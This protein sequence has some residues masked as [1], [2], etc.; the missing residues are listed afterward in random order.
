MDISS[1]KVLKGRSGKKKDNVK[2]KRKWK[3]NGYRRS[4][5]RDQKRFNNEYNRTEMNKRRG[6]ENTTERAYTWSKNI[7]N[8]YVCAAHVLQRWRAGGV[9]IMGKFGEILKQINDTD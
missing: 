5:K 2:G 8:E 6:S 9:I 4:C 1:I 7:N 3:P